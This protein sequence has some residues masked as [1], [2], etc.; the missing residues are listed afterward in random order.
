MIVRLCEK[1]GCMELRRLEFAN[2]MNKRNEELSKS[3]EKL[4]LY[5]DPFEDCGNTF[6]SKMKRCKD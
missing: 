1:Q 6:R 4:P 3:K 2:C 5:V